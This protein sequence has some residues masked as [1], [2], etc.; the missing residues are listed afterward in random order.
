MEMGNS[1]IFVDPTCERISE[2]VQRLN[3]RY[4]IGKRMSLKTQRSLSTSFISS[5][6]V[7]SFSE[8]FNLWKCNILQISNSVHNVDI[9]FAVFSSGTTGTPKI[10][11]V[12][13]LCLIPN[14]FDLR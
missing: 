1:F 4:F 12:P 5:V 10:I 7:P 2:I 3:I 13:H 11:Q 14:I 6:N 8:C 9:A